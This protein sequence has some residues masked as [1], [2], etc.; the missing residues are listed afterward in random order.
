MRAVHEKR[1]MTGPSS[2]PAAAELLR[3]DLILQSL[4]A[5]ALA[6]NGGRLI[7]QRL[8]QRLVVVPPKLLFCNRFK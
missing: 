2:R 4:Q 3:V 5:G 7:D 8:D 1:R 6:L